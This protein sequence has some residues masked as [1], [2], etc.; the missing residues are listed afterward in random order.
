MDTRQDGG[1]GERV[2]LR[3]RGLHPQSGAVRELKAS[4]VGAPRAG[5]VSRFAPARR[6]KRS[7]RRLISVPALASGPSRPPSHDARAP[8]GP[9]RDPHSSPKG[10]PDR[11]GADTPGAAQCRR[12]SRMIRRSQPRLRFHMPASRTWLVA[13]VLIGLFVGAW[14]GGSA[15][16]HS[17]PGVDAAR[18][19]DQLQRRVEHPPRRTSSPALTSRWA[20]SVLR[21]GQLAR[22]AVAAALLD[23]HERAFC[24]GRIAETRGRA[25]RLVGAV[26]SRAKETRHWSSPQWRAIRTIT[27]AVVRSQRGISACH[28]RVTSIPVGATPEPTET[29]APVT[30]APEATPPD[31]ES[32]VHPSETGIVEP[33]PPE[34]PVQEVPERDP[35][36]DPEDP[37]N[38]DPPWLP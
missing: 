3:T 14:T 4:H 7:A 24:L 6:G 9:Q 13:L 11:S 17:A 21:T 29:P 37:P 12:P 31:S 18:A 23:E 36:H 28:A 8:R 19:L 35:A 32:V 10:A 5:A 30:I 2:R 33:P 1:V 15:H 16:A 26:A 22:E 20:V 25:S 34:A 27:N 38:P